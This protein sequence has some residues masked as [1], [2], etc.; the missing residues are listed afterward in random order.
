MFA[1]PS[2]T[3]FVKGGMQ[4]WKHVHQIIEEHEKSKLHRESAEVY[5]LRANKA[6]IRSLVSE[7]QISVHREQVGKKRQVMEHVV[8]TVKVLGKRGLSY[9]G[10]K[11]EAA[12]SLNNMAL[13]H[14]NFLEIAA[15]QI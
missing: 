13:D 4:A 1:K 3:P 12:Y 9:R 8:N 7:K 6:D 5:F 15:E 14:G 11:H 10:D 2:D